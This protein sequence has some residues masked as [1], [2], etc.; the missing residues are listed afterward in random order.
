MSLQPSRIHLGKNIWLTAL[1]VLTLTLIM[2]FNFIWSTRDQSLKDFGSFIAAG[3]LASHG[4]NPY[5]TE[6][7]LIFHVEFSK[8]GLKASLP[9]LNPPISILFA[10]ILATYDPV[11]SLL[12]WKSITAILYFLC[13]LA[14]ILVFP[15][16]STIL[17]IF[18]AF[19]LAGFWHT[20]ELGQIYAPLA[21][22]S[23]GAFIF[24]IKQKW[25]LAGIL[26]GCL[27]AIKP[28]FLIWPVFLLLGNY[29]PTALIAFATAGALS[30]LPLLIY[31]PQVYFQWLQASLNFSALSFPGNSSLVGLVSR[32]GSP[33]WGEGLALLITIIFAIL[34][35]FKRPNLLTINASGLLISLLAS[36]IAWVGYTI[37]LLP[38]LYAKHWRV[39]ESLAALI[40]VIPFPV[41]LTYFENSQ[42]NYIFWGWLY[43]FALAILSASVL[44]DIFN[45]SS[46]DP[47]SISIQRSTRMTP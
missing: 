43:G 41:V 26:I 32:F 1:G 24:F 45:K 22:F 33:G 38:F 9:N 37:T 17:K 13:V 3:Q 5:S 28:N 27:V 34:I 16:N 23:T 8:L 39:P 29:V 6:S 44:F 7:P 31:S 25:G 40:L 18:W 15:I 47:L 30:L 14:L 20:I 21:L 12:V 4:E 2:I 10:Q 19:S 11:T 46:L 36:P 42:F 35:Y